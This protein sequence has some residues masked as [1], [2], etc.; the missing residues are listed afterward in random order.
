MTLILYIVLLQLGSKMKTFTIEL[1]I[2]ALTTDLN[3]LERH[4]SDQNKEL[5]SETSKRLATAFM[6]LADVLSE[7]E[8]VSREC[9]L[10]SFSLQPSP[11]TLLKIEDI[12]RQGGHEVVETG[13]WL[14]KLHPPISEH[15]E[16]CLQCDKCGDFMG[17]LVLEA[18]LNTNLTLNEALTT[19]RLCISSQLCDDLAV[20]LCSP[21]Y[22]FLSWDQEWRH[23]QR[24]C[25]MYL[26]SPERTKNYVTELKYIDIDYNQFKNVKSEPVEETEM[27]DYISNCEELM[28]EEFKADQRLNQY[29]KDSRKP[30]RTK[31][32]NE[33]YDVFV[34]PPK[35]NTDPLVLKSLRSYRKTLKRA[36]S[37]DLE[38]STSEKVFINSSPQGSCAQNSLNP[39]VNNLC[40]NV[41]IY[42]KF[43]INS[44][45]NLSEFIQ[46]NDA[47]K[48]NY[49]SSN[50]NTTNYQSVWNNE[51]VI[52][53][54]PEYTMTETYDDSTND[55]I[56][57]FSFPALDSGNSLKKVVNK[58]DSNTNFLENV[59]EPLKPYLLTPKKFEILSKA[60]VEPMEKVS[61]T[62]DKVPPWFENLPSNEIANENAKNHMQ[63]ENFCKRDGSFSVKDDK[64]G[65]TDNT[66][67]LQNVKIHEVRTVNF[68]LERS[69]IQRK[70]DNKSRAKKL[71]AGINKITKKGTLK[72]TYNQRTGTFV[73]RKDLDNGELKTKDAQEETI[74][75]NKPVSMETS[76]D[77]T[78]PTKRRMLSSTSQIVEAMI[79][80]PPTLNK[81]TIV[82]NKHVPI[83]KSLANNIQI[84][85][86]ITV[87]NTPDQTTKQIG[88]KKPISKKKFTN[89]DLEFTIEPSIT[90]ANELFNT[91]Y[92]FLTNNPSL[93]V[94]NFA[95]EREAG[96]L[97]EKVRVCRLNTFDCQFLTKEFLIQR[98][99]EKPASKS[100]ETISLV[101]NEPVQKK[102]VIVEN[103]QVP[104]KKAMI[105]E[106]EDD[107]IYDIIVPTSQRKINEIILGRHVLK[108]TM[109]RTKIN[110]RE[111]T[112]STVEN[113]ENSF[114][115]TSNMSPLEEIIVQLIE[116][117][118]TTEEEDVE[119]FEKEKQTKPAKISDFMEFERLHAASQTYFNNN[120]PETSDSDAEYSFLLCEASLPENSTL[121]EEY[122][123][124]KFKLKDLSI[125]V[126]RLNVNPPEEETPPKKR[127]TKPKA[128]VTEPKY[129]RNKRKE[130]KKRTS[131]K[132]SSWVSEM[133]PANKNKEEYKSSPLQDVNPRVLLKRIDSEPKWCPKKSP[134]SGAKDVEK[135][136]PRVILKRLDMDKLKNINVNSVLENVPGL[137]DTE[138]IRPGNVDSVVQVVQVAG[139]RSTTTVPTNNQTSTQV[140]PHIQRIGQPRVDKP[141]SNSET[142]SGTKSSTASS[143]SKPSSTQ[144]STLI[145]ILSQQ[146]RPTSSPN[147]PRP[148]RPPFINILS[149]QILRP[150]TSPTK[151][152]T[153]STSTE[154]QVCTV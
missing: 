118:T 37:D 57:K 27:N 98:K 126:K 86:E 50:S 38:S 123:K 31:S 71:T 75:E 19:E 111:Y 92:D 128:K 148:T 36:C 73:K 134:P 117:D 67:D 70:M 115:I 4:K 82:T 103:K 49:Q 46:F 105:N 109:N 93:K 33:Y 20:I 6:K 48:S 63:K 51:N 127:K 119:A 22:Q 52:Q 120:P 79:H 21:R 141:E 87:D 14:C 76:S 72:F 24:L 7:H 108:K 60:N 113:V 34:P 121:D 25:A 96:V 110:R 41:N 142:A 1:Y 131:K 66:K 99:G 61:C 116:F 12:A 55:Y 28:A 91:S 125:V 136:V 78:N 94:V 88:A 5:E 106:S 10:T 143:I 42:E 44:I 47:S 65:L 11:E 144:P 62:E 133:P 129:A 9:V 95:F 13:K 124:K 77:E 112:I 40:T 59:S 8:N 146:A 147:N 107:S 56:A 17:K 154:A 152:S 64:G 43:F 97:M 90:S 135:M 101:E 140:S 54:V 68:S 137:H 150:A 153:S 84:P 132:R 130:N 26:Y 16:I 89:N 139:G 83:E 145:N 102:D 80:N 29:H 3:V 69:P 18:A 100:V 81:E 30:G 149:Q 58:E 32:P 35:A 138:M 122:L 104:A 2:Q 39:S 23:L 15:D 74:V 85:M 53:N 45:S 114:A 151:H